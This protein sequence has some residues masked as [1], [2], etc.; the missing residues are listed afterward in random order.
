MVEPDCWI[1]GPDGECFATGDL[2]GDGLE[3]CAFP[4]APEAD[5]DKFLNQCLDAS[6]ATSFFD[7]AARIPASTWVPGDPLPPVP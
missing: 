4:D 1:A 2:D 3:E 7:N 5:S 6:V